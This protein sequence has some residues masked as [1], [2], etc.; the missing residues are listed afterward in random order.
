MAIFAAATGFAGAVF[1]V[2]GYL[3]KFQ[4]MVEM[5][6]GYDPSKVTDRQGLAGW[7][8]GN[9][10]LLG[11]LSFVTAAIAL[12]IPGISPARLVPIHVAALLALIARLAL[13]TRR[14]EGDT[15]KS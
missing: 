3:V 14:Y 8:G 6:A 15:H 4:G 9:L 7:V 12:L 2:L 10:F 1:L 5:L 11:L 13:G